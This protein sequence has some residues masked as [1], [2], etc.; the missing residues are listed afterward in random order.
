[1]KLETYKQMVRAVTAAMGG[2]VAVGIVLNNIPLLLAG[3]TI[4]MLSIYLAKRKVTEQ[5]KD[6]RTIMI[7]QKSSQVTLSITVVSLAVVGLSLFLLSRQGYLGYEELGFQ[8]EIIGLLVMG[9]KAFFD[10]YYRDRLGG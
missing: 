3:L 7:N 9:L 5:D 4:G 10:W 2:I 8:L 6:E 1:M